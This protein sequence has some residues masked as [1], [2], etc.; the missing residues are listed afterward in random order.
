MTIKNRHLL[1]IPVT[2]I[3]LLLITYVEA[4]W[5]RPFG[6][7]SLNIVVQNITANA[8]VEGWTVLGL[9]LFNN[10][11]GTQVGIGTATPTN[12]LTVIGVTNS[13]NFT[14]SLECTQIFGGTDSDFCVDGGGAGVDGLDG[15]W[16][17]QGRFLFNNTN[18]TFVGIG[19]SVPVGLL[20]VGTLNNLTIN[21]SFE[22]AN[23]TAFWRF[24]EGSGVKCFDSSGNNLTGNITGA[25]YIDSKMGNGTGNFSLRFDGVQDFC[26]IPDR[27]ILDVTQPFSISVWVNKTDTG[28]DEI[29]VYHNIVGTDT[30]YGIQIDAS[31]LVNIFSKVSGEQTRT[32]RSDSPIATGSWMHIVAVV[33]GTGTA[34]AHLWFD[35]VKQATSDGSDVAVDA[36]DL[37][38]YIGAAADMSGDFTGD[39]DEVIVFNRELNQTEIT[40]L[41]NN[42]LEVINKTRNFT[43]FLRGGQFVV[44]PDGHIN[45]TANT[46]NSTFE[47]DVQFKRNV[48]IDGTLFGGS[49]LKIAGGLNFSGDFNRVHSN[50]T[51]ESL[52]AIIESQ[53]R[54]IK[55]LTGEVDILRGR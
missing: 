36:D 52:W 39:L 40:E 20:D 14:G 54:Q 50:G 38:F 55:N 34:D 2:F 6:N 19:T 35:A 16:T 33:N 42:G 31:E 46:S 48:F 9:F 22:T 4:D 47:G 30:N 13:T 18:G 15:D 28:F 5:V 23:A 7:T 44:R 26:R 17:S 51:V 27:D 11:P 24:E 43:F 3:L 32:Q 21:E 41:F 10:T 12:E 8:E 29:F 53:A 1:L 25:T 49:E 45:V 37:D